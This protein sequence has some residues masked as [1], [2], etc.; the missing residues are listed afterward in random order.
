LNLMMMMMM[1]GV[2]EAVVELVKMLHKQQQN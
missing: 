1:L 2:V